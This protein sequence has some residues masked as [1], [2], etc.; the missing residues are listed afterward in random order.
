[1]LTPSLPF[2]RYCRTASL[3]WL[4]LG[5]GLAAAETGTAAAATAIAAA[6]TATTPAADLPWLD[7]TREHVGNGARWLARSVNSWFGDQPLEPHGHV[8]GYVRLGGLW[9][10]HSGFK[11]NVRFR[12]R[13]DLPNLRDKAY[14]FVGQDN[15]REVVTDVPEGFTREQLLLREG[16]RQDQ[17]FFAGLGYAWR[18]DVDLRLGFRG[19]LKPYAQ[20]RYSAQR[21]LSPRDMVLFRQSLFW[22]SRDSLGLTTVL[23]FERALNQSLSARWSTVGTI[24]RRSHGLEWQSALGLFWQLPEQRSASL[25]ALVQGRTG[26]VK[27]SNYGLRAA[28][29]QPVYADWLFARATLGHFWP[30]DAQHNPRVRSWAVGLSVEMH[31]E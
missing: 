5:A 15:Q 19:G 23:D 11:G 21:A 30:R 24:T 7:S 25:E 4:G 20:V 29:R 17:S 8:S 9:D 28:W 14:A 1:M 6:D 12:L 16:R 31:F 13:A 26:S 2:A 27:I 18:D 10:Q 3:I 22:S